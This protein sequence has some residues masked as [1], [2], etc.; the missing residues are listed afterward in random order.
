LAAEVLHFR[1]GS[2][3]TAPWSGTAPLTRAKLTAGMLHSIESALSEAYEYMPLGTQVLPFPESPQTDLEK[4]GHGF[5]GKRGRVL[6]RESVAV[7]SA[8][9]PVPQSDWK[10][11]D[12]TPDLSKSMSVESLEASR[13]SILAVYGVLPGWFND[14][15]TGPMVRECQRHLAQWQLQP[16]A[17]LIAHEATEKLG[18][19][20]ALDV[21][22][23]LQAFD[24][25]NRART[26][27]AIVQALALAKQSGVDPDQVMK[28]VNWGPE[29]TE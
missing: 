23:P 25:G 9:G 12:V 24:S 7:T 2:D 17:N 5:R 10:P 15:T 11:S 20:V 6:L 1:I 21:M 19:P 18:Q 8:G 14:A 16:I 27:N 4:L 26:V 29:L 3:A 13:A 22:Q 28:L